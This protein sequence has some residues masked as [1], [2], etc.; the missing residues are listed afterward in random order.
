MF[1]LAREP[2]QLPGCVLCSGSD[3]QI[4]WMQEALRTRGLRDDTTCIV[5]DI[6]P[7][8]R[9]TI[10]S[11][12]KK[13]GFFRTL[14]GLRSRK[15]TARASERSAEVGTVEE[16]FEEGSAILAER[17]VI[18]GI[19]LVTTLFFDQLCGPIL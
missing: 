13:K 14:F 19:L 16:L 8:S 11:K 4:F 9:S 7:P 6:E 3:L 10:P 5:V 15:S 1:V 2:R 17:W 18:P 12:P